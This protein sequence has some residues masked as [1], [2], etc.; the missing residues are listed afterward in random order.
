MTNTATADFEVYG[1]GT[2]Y[3]LAPLNATAKEF[4]YERLGDEAQFLGEAVAVEHR[5]IGD[6]V[7]DLRANGFL[8]R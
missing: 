5:Y 1:G 4:L 2:V 8:V 3:M 6:I 7:E